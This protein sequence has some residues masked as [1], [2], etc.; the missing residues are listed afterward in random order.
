MT[1]HNFLNFSNSLEDLIF[2][3]CFGKY[4]PIFSLLSSIIKSTSFL[5][6][7]AI[8]RSNVAFVGAP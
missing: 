2:M 3:A 6:I 8:S 1:T 4:F 5:V 7:E